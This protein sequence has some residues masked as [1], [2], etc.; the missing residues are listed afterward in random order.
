MDVSLKFRAT[1]GLI[2][3]SGEAGKKTGKRL[4]K[5][6]DSPEVESYNDATLSDGL[7]SGG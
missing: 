7:K 4:G 2:R 1:L 5:P 6:L 3:G